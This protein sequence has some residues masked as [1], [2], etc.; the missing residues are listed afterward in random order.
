MEVKKWTHAPDLV[1]FQEAN[2][3]EEEATFWQELIDTY[4]FPLEHDSKQQTKTKEDL[5]E[6]RY[7][8]RILSVLLH[9]WCFVY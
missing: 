7:K 4:L 6:L 9:W 5:L 2:I 1:Q 3:C 8:N